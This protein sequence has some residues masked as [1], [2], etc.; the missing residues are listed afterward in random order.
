MTTLINGMCWRRAS[1]TE[2]RSMTSRTADSSLASL[3]PTPLEYGNA[4][5]NCG[6]ANKVKRL[7]RL[8]H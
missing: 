2:R 8:A 6:H 4:S 3:R 5:E 1:P 7:H